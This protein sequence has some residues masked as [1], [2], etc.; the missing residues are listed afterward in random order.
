[1]KIAF[2]WQAFALQK[3]GGVSKYYSEIAKE[4]NTSG[5]EVK[6]FTPVYRNEY[7]RA[8]PSSIKVGKYL[9]DFPWKMSRFIYSANEVISNKLL[10]SWKPDLLHRTYYYSQTNKHGVPV[11]VTVYDMIHELYPGMF[12]LDDRTAIMKKKSLDSADLI[13]CISEST[14]KDLLNYYP[15]YENKV[16]VIHLGVRSRATV[17][18]NNNN[19]IRLCNPF[20][21]YVGSRAGYKNFLRFI[22]ALSLSKNIMNDFEIVSYGGPKFTKEEIFIFKKLGFRNDQIK[23]FYGSD[24]NLDYLYAGAHAFIYP[25]LY[26]GFGLP[27]LEAMTVGCPVICGNVSSLPEVVGSAAEMF[28]PDDTYDIIRAIENVV[29]SP[30]KM[31]ELSAAGLN[32]SAL[33]NWDRCAN[34][35]IAAYKY[36]I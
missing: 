17:T 24:A 4:F 27:P 8:L 6:I 5:H 34:S 30:T 1:M 13:I 9:N 19:I 22:E 7:L 26:E 28:A 31:A 15:G 32:R 14:K 25:S 2:D 35:T 23:H 16:R 29:Y 33:F 11:V 36:I 18:K 21:L 10:A 3:Y 12:R 20:L